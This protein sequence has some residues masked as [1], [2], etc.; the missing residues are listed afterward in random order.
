M[1]GSAPAGGRLPPPHTLWVRC[2]SGYGFF[3]LSEEGIGLTQRLTATGRVRLPAIRMLT[4]E[5]ERLKNELVTTSKNWGAPQFPVLL[6]G[7]SFWFASL[8]QFPP[9][10]QF[11]VLLSQNLPELVTSE[12]IV[13]ALPPGRTPCGALPGSG[14]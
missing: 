6:F 11:N 13:V 5:P 1:S 14:P 8:G 12:K 9:G 7:R 3:G 4:L 10:D 2:S